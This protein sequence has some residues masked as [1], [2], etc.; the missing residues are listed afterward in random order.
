M[1][2]ISKLGS[3]GFGLLLLTFIGFIVVLCCFIVHLY[4]HFSLVCKSRRIIISAVSGSHSQ[5]HRKLSSSNIATQDI[6][7]ISLIG[8]LEFYPLLTLLY[9]GSVLISIA[10]M[11]VFYHQ[12][13]Q[14]RMN[15]IEYCPIH[16]NISTFWHHPRQPTSLFSN[17]NGFAP[18]WSYI[19]ML[20]ALVE[21]L[22]HFY[23]FYDAK[24]MVSHLRNATKLRI[25]GLFSIYNLIFS[26]I[27]LLQMHIYF[28]LFPVIILTHFTFNIYCILRFVSILNE[29]M[30][31]LIS[32]AHPNWFYVSQKQ[33]L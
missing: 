17:Q 13:F 12:T 7:C 8:H 4:H 33:K 31:K 24:Y 2:S 14:S 32:I 5:K 6:C 23:K 20:L 1:F 27:Y 29:G 30:F 21:S 15:I 26:V 28:G 10:A 16:R 3:G 11:A 22:S 19:V 18:Y 9:F 25:F